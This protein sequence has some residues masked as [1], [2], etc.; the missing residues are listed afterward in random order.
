VNDVDQN[1]VYESPAVFAQISATT[2]ATSSATPPAACHRMNDRMGHAM[3]RADVRDD[4]DQGAIR[5]S[6]GSFF[7]W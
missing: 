2:V 6:S 3:T 1:D 7:T 5:R 4:R